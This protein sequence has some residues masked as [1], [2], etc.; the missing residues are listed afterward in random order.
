MYTAY[1]R[2][3]SGIFLALLRYIYGLSCQYLIQICRIYKANIRR[4]SDISQE[5][6]A[7]F[8]NILGAL[9]GMEIKTLPGQLGY[10]LALAWQNWI[11]LLKNG[12]KGIDQLDLVV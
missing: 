12:T 9:G 3:I 10:G 8:K 6:K 11:H 5:S 1:L 4:T 2:Y 7:C